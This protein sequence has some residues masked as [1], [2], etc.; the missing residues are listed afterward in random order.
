MKV[1]DVVFIQNKHYFMKKY[2]VSDVFRLD[3][4]YPLGWAS[5]MSD[6]F[7][8]VTRVKELCRDHFRCTQ[9]FMFLKE[10]VILLS[11]SKKGNIFET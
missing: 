1:G 6:L 7:G 4:A 5:G 9:G 10:D 11:P 2:G 3:I 8:T